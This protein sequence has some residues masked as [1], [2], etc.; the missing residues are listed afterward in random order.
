MDNEDANLKQ[1][2]KSQKHFNLFFFNDLLLFFKIHFIIL[3]NSLYS[4][5]FTVIGAP[6]CYPNTTTLNNLNQL[7]LLTLHIIWQ[8]RKSSIINPQPLNA[9]PPRSLLIRHAEL[10]HPD[11]A[12][13][14]TRTVHARTRRLISLRGKLEAE[15]RVYCEYLPLFTSFVAARHSAGLAVDYY[16]Q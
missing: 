4:G 7:W 16:E 1:P 5:S 2:F 15:T 8:M 11:F 14:N 3:I 6:E 10:M 12:G 13:I 9:P